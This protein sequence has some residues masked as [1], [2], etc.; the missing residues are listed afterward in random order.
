MP[1]EERGTP[2]RGSA[3]ACGNV[4]VRE[5]KALPC[6]GDAGVERLSTGHEA[7]RRNAVIRRCARAR[8]QRVRKRPRLGVPV[9]YSE[10]MRGKLRRGSR[11]RGR[12]V[13]SPG[14]RGRGKLTSPSSRCRRGNCR[15][16]TLSTP[17]CR[18]RSRRPIDGTERGTSAFM[19]RCVGRRN[20]GLRSGRLVLVG[21]SV[22]RRGRALLGGG[23]LPLLDAFVRL[24]CAFGRRRGGG[25][26]RLGK[27]GTAAG[28][29]CLKRRGEGHCQLS[30]LFRWAR[31]GGG[32]SRNRRSGCRRRCRRSRVGRGRGRGSRGGAR[33]WGGGLFD[34]FLISLAAGVIQS[35]REGASVFRAAQRLDAA[36]SRS[37]TR[38]GLDGG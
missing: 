9:A 5:R 24:R 33:R 34:G 38:F 36:G 10:G 13:C 27:G 26:L 25:G 4:H 8:G 31:C 7:Q 35:R 30:L 6:E 17:C 18:I 14:R 21:M 29:V 37:A 19:G 20:N 22:P 16:K 23:D 12:G 15:R 1:A 3:S 11:R 28:R 2:P 32:R